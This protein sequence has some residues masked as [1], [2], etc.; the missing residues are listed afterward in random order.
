VTFIA[1]ADHPCVKCDTP[2]C[3]EHYMWSGDAMIRLADYGWLDVAVLH[4]CPKHRAEIER[5]ATEGMNREL[6][7]ARL[8]TN[9]LML[10]LVVGGLGL[11]FALLYFTTNV[12]R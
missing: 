12:F 8:R 3:E 7:A 2:D 1:R 5:R 4:Y 11:A 10:A 9:L 6:R